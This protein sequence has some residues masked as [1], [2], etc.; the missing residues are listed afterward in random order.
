MISDVTVGLTQEGHLK[1]QSLK[2]AG[3]FSDMLDGY[4]FAIGLA[5]RRS[6]IAS[7]EIKT[8]TIFNVGSLDREG[9]IKDMVCTLFPD[10]IPRPYSFAERLAEAGVDELMQLYQSGQLRFADLFNSPSTTQDIS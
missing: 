5:I 6:L 10:A 8:N 2:D 7:E 3:I 1:L 4:R 9:I